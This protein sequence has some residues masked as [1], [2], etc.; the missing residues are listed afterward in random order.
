MKAAGPGNEGGIGLEVVRLLARRGMAVVLG[1]RVP[2]G[3]SRTGAIYGLPP[4][5]FF[6]SL[7]VATSR[8]P[9]STPPSKIP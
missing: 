4:S 3:A 9:V 7:W 2:A 5:R 1:A 6:F 8:R